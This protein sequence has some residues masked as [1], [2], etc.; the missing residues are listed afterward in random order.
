MIKERFI[1][2]IC[3]FDPNAIKD[4]ATYQNPKQYPEGI[5]YVIVNGK[6]TVKNGS[7][8]DTRNGLVLRKSN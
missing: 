8:L 1:A 4:V 5:E 6:V 3:I 7:L 2:D